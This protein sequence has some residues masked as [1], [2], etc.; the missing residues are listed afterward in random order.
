MFPAQTASHLRGE[1]LKQLVF[2]NDCGHNIR[3]ELTKMIGIGFERVIGM[4]RMG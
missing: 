4:L 1:E 2:L 3:P